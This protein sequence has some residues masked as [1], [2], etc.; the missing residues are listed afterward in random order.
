M[1]YLNKSFTVPYMSKEYR[2]NWSK[3]F[4]KDVAMKVFRLRPDAKLPRREHE[5]DAGADVFYCPTHKEPILFESRGEGFDRR[6]YPFESHIV[7]TGIKVEVPKGYMLEVKNKG[8]IAAKRNLVVG[9]C[10]VDS[11]YDGEVFVN[12]HNIGVEAQNIK[13]GEKIA[14]IV[15][16]PIA[17]CTFQEVFDENEINI[18]SKRGDGA[19]GSTGIK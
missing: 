14:Q 19:L 11:G 13:P 7:P 2:D 18:D 1:N 10:V 12:L 6:I 9:S 5:D 15:L 4:R 16:I 17:N 8:G 3:I